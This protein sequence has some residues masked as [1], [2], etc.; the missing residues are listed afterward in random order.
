[1]TRQYA[2]LPKL[3]ADQNALRIAPFENHIMEALTE[4]QVIVL[5]G[6]TGCGYVAPCAPHH[7]AYS[8]PDCHFQRNESL[9]KLVTAQCAIISVHGGHTDATFYLSPIFCD[10]CLTLGILEGHRF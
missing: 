3:Q 2:R 10:C 5:A 8:G 4:L 9:H 7:R 6:N 1:V